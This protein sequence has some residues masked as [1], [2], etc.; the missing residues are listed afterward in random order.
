MAYVAGYDHDVFVS[1][2]HIDNERF[3]SQDGW[4]TSFVGNLKKLLDM[5]LGRRDT[6]IWMDRGLTGN[7]SFP[8]QIETA[9]R[10]SATLLVIASP[11]YLQSEWCTRERNAFLNAVRDR[12]AAGT[13]IFRVDLDQFNRNAVPPEFN[14]LLGY[15]FWAKDAL[16]NARILGFPVFD[17]LRDSDYFAALTKL[18][19]ELADHLRQQGRQPGSAPGVPPSTSPTVFLADVTDDLE[20]R[21]EELAA[22]VKQAGLNVLPQTWY[23]PDDYESYRRRMADD[24]S[25]S[26]LFVQLLSDLGGKRPPGWPSRLPLALYEEAKRAGLPI[27]QWRSQEL[28]VKRVEAAAPEH[29]RL[30]DGPEVRASGIE[31]FKRA[32]VEEATRVPKP[33]APVNGSRGQVMVFVN[34]DS[35]DRPLAQELGRCLL[36]CGIGYSMPLVTA[37]PKPGEVREDLELNL[38]TC[39]GLILLYG[40]TP[41]SW[42]RRQLAQGRKIL[43]QRESPLEALALVAGPGSDQEEIGYELPN[44]QFLDCRKGLTCAPVAAFASALQQTR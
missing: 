38:S 24:L 39:D 2:A 37:N 36:S 10:R 14:D 27:R 19:V 7:E 40:H 12:S 17:P 43:S 33:A 9:L 41:A 1:Y 8:L 20:D 29:Y 28:D 15:D 11:S 42:V 31:E 4:V 6:V 16:G 25:R 5:A 30:L 3:G 35:A 26:K 44:M 22:Y 32:V 23:P 34:S 13:K 18:K 21:R